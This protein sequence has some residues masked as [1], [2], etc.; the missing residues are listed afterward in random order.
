MIK[1]QVKHMFTIYHPQKN[2]E[3]GKEKIVI[4]VFSN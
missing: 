3:P 4:E 1:S 2:L